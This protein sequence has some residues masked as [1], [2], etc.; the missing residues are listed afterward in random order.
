MIKLFIADNYNL[1]ESELEAI[2]SLGYEIT[3]AR[4]NQ[5]PSEVCENH[6][7]MEVA[8][9]EHFY[10]KAH[11]GEMPNLKMVQMTVAGFD[12]MGP[13]IFDTYKNTKFYSGSGTYGVSLAEWTVGKTLEI[14]RQAARFEGYQ[15]QHKWSWEGS[16]Q[17]KELWGKTVLILGTG[18]VGSACASRYKAFDCKVIGLNTTGRAVP[19]FD[20]CC[21]REQLS[22]ILPECDVICV[23]IPRTEKTL[24][25]LDEETLSHCKQGAVLVVNSRG[26]LVDEKALCR[27]LDSGHLLGAALDCFET[28]PL[29]EDS[30]LWEQKNLIIYPH[31]AGVT[32][33]LRN[34]YVKRYLENLAR[35]A[36]GE[37]PVGLI[38]YERGY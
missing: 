38:R 6:E 30:P 20:A 3:L 29:P 1:T 26:R 19:G 14:Y 4:P 37:E 23:A 9:C 34:R 33:G 11:L 32:M 22:E 8:L 12:N 28:E 21:T 31:C 13:V 7:E 5:A 24:Y 27:M 35:Y 10:L 36:K 15:K 17:T 16:T 2:R 18:D 25:L